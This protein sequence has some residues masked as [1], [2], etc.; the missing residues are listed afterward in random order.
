MENFNK[1]KLLK[2]EELKSGKIEEENFELFV[3]NTSNF[4][5]KCWHFDSKQV[6]DWKEY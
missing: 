4:S 3:A 1:K 2:N 5:A 6:D